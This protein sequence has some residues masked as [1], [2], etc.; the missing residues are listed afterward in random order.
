MVVYGTEYLTE[1]ID[2]WFKFKSLNYI[3]NYY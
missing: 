2:F 3:K 1:T